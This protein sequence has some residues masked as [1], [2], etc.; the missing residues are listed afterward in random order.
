[1]SDSLILPT[2]LFPFNIV[3]AVLDLLFIHINLRISLPISTIT[4]WDFDWECT[5]S[6]D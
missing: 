1:M 4:C 3:F 6:I 5:D 2:F